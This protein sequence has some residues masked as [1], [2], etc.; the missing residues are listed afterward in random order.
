MRLTARMCQNLPK[1]FAAT[2]HG[3]NHVRIVSSSRTT[4]SFAMEDPAASLRSAVTRKIVGG[5]IAPDLWVSV[6]PVTEHLHSAKIFR[7]IPTRKRLGPNDLRSPV[8][9]RP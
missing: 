2:L 3:S 1:H 5:L 4:A 8:S 7:T 6:E 9:E